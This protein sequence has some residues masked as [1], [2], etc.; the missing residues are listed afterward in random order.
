MPAMANASPP[1]PMSSLCTCN[2]IVCWI[3]SRRYFLPWHATSIP[4]VVGDAGLLVDPDDVDG[5]A[6][7][8]RTVLTD[9]DTVERLV[10]R[11][12]ERAGLFT[13]KRMGGEMLAVFRRLV[14]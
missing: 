13:L 1:S 7:A 3:S 11:G 6:A 10:R 2:H 4:E 14:S 5:F 12:K 8:M 9:A